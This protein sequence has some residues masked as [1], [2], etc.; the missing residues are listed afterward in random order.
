MD[1]NKFNEA[2]KQVQELELKRK[3]ENKALKERK[4]V[5]VVEYTSQFTD[6]QRKEMLD[7]SQAGISG[8][9]EKA[10][11]LREKFKE[12]W[13]ALK[14]ELN[15]HKQTL[16]LLNYEIENG[17]PKQKNKIDD[18]KIAQGIIIIKREGINDIEAN[19]KEDKNWYKT[20]SLKLATAL[21]L[22]VSSGVVRSIMYDV[23]NV[24]KIYNNK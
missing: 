7:R 13:K 8:I 5:V 9:K 14:E 1:I 19:F 20:T 23:G 21:N 17:L 3:Q 18:E 4:R 10:T 12:D 11:K 24:V 6:D 16:S 2:L 22:D 15:L